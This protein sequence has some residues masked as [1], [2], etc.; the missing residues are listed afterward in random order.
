MYIVADFCCSIFRIGSQRWHMKQNL[1]IENHN[2]LEEIWRLLRH[3]SFG[4]LLARPTKRKSS[5]GR[6]W[7]Y[8]AGLGIISSA[9]EIFIS[10]QALLELPNTPGQG[11]YCL[12][13]TLPPPTCAFCL[14]V[15]CGFS[16]TSPSLSGKLMPVRARCIPGR[17]FG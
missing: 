10:G 16:V 5:I 3:K 4:N 1:I 7:H 9:F 14:P 8:L 2:K 17:I 11:S 6:L 13:M 15:A 12:S